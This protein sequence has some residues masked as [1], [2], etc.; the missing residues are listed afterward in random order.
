M[1]QE[2]LSALTGGNVSV[3]FRKKLHVSWPLVGWESE[4]QLQK[5]FLRLLLALPFYTNVRKLSFSVEFLLYVLRADYWRKIR[6]QYW[7]SSVTCSAPSA[8]PEGYSASGWR[9]T[10]SWRICV[11]VCIHIT[12]IDNM[13]NTGIMWQVKSFFGHLW[14]AE[15]RRC[16]EPV[17]KQLLICTFSSYGATLWFIWSR[18][19]VHLM[20]LN[21][22]FSVFLLCFWSPPPPEGNIRL[23][24]Y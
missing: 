11:S 4:K 18:V 15:T 21:P 24:S 17:G 12:H 2:Q 3:V 6:V 19:S 20:N 23:F 13:W 22:I 7:G 9:K 14:A 8:L 5:V 1:C 10:P 16:G